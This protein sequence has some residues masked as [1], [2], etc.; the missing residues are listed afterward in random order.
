MTDD[1]T[2][3]IRSE[4][5][6]TIEQLKAT[7]EKLVVTVGADLI[8]IIE[9]LVPNMAALLSLSASSSLASASV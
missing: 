2:L 3:Q 7:F 9:K 6:K 5:A 8:P 4:F 1:P